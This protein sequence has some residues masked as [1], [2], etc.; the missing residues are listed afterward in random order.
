[1]NQEWEFKYHNNY[2][3]KF[4]FKDIK[5]LFEALSSPPPPPL[6]ASSLSAQTNNTQEQWYV[7][8]PVAHCTYFTFSSFADSLK[9]YNQ[10][11]MPM[12]RLKHHFEPATQEPVISPSA[13]STNPV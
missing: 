13:Q 6:T 8:S 12:I 5:C 9:F 3:L 4:F 10:L 11:I 7:S 2:V 1:M